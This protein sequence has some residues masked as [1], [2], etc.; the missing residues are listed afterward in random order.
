VRRKHWKTHRMT[1]LRL[2]WSGSWNTGGCTFA[3]SLPVQHINNRICSRLIN[4]FLLNSC[5]LQNSHKCYMIHLRCYTNIISCICLQ[6]SPKPKPR[7]PKGL[8]VICNPYK[9]I[10]VTFYKSRCV[11]A[12]LGSYCPVKW[13]VHICNEYIYVWVSFECVT[14]LIH[15]YARAR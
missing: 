12:R 8:P 13:F 15:I 6:V 14:L 4:V 5:M 7:R 2:L 10:Y 3:W 9:Q 11:A 1:V